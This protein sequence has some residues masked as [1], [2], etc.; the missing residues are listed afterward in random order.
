MKA[1]LKSNPLARQIANPEAHRRAAVI[2]R[3]TLR[4]LEQLKI[5]MKQ[6]H[7]KFEKRDVIDS[8]NW[9]SNGIYSRNQL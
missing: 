2:R 7:P 8:K 1:F 5:C 9:F 6:I 4:L 3:N